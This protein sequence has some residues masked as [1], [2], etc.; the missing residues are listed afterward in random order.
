MFSESNQFQLNLE[1][2]FSCMFHKNVCVCVSI[3]ASVAVLEHLYVNDDDEDDDD[4]D[5]DD[6]DDVGCFHILCQHVCFFVNR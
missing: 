3:C 2:C 5:G 1:M 4:N 6:D